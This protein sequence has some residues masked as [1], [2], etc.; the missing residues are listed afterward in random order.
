[1]T[2]P[3]HAR[4]DASETIDREG[5][6]RIIILKDASNSLESILVL[7]VVSQIVKGVWIFLVYVRSCVINCHRQ[8]HTPSIHQVLNEGWLR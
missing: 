7:V 8:T 1:M 4:W 6:I 5:F 3:Y 2:D